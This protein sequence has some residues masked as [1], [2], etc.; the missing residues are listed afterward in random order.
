M[1]NI[2]DDIQIEMTTAPTIQSLIDWFSIHAGGKTERTIEETPKTDTSSDHDI[3]EPQLS[4][5]TQTYENFTPYILRTHWE[6]SPVLM[7]D[8]LPTR[9]F[10]LVGNTLCTIG[11][12][13][14]VEAKDSHKRTER[15]LLNYMNDEEIFS[16]RSH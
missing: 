15:L 5:Y 11:T 3:L 8:P 7:S 2:P 14:S 12:H 16:L 9:A 6:A 1:F 10:R 4:E 13:S